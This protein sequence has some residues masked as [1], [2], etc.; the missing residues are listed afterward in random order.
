MPTSRNINTPSLFLFEICNQTTVS[1]H[2]NS[3]NNPKN[4]IINIFLIRNCKPTNAIHHYKD[5]I[6]LTL[7]CFILSK[8]SVFL[9]FA[10]NLN[11]FK[12]QTWVCCFSFSF[13]STKRQLLNNYEKCFLFHLKSPFH[14]LKIFI[15]LHS[16]FPLFFSLSGIAQ[17]DRIQI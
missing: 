16:H 6:L 8:T 13:F 15:F 17:V 7:R 3:L 12:I 2:P 9:N 4:K 11:S 14:A 10:F 1:G 5:Y